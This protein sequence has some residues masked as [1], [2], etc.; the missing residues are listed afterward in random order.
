MIDAQVDALHNA[1][2]VDD[3]VAITLNVPVLGGGGVTLPSSVTPATV[4][5]LIGPPNVT[6]A[7]NVVVAPAGYDAHE[8]HSPVHDG[9]DIETTVLLPDVFLPT[10]KYIGPLWLISPK[11]AACPLS[12]RDDNVT[13]KLV[14]CCAVAQLFLIANLTFAVDH[15]ALELMVKV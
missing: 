1:C 9:V 7:L 6:P 12:K 4:N 11:V 15:H 14:N 8:H 13:G 5:E 2:K 3:D 10:V